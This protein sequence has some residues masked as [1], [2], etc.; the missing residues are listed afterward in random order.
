MASNAECVQSTSEL[1]RQAVRRAILS[2]RS[3]LDESFSLTAMAALAFASRFHFN[4]FFHEVTGI[5]PCQFLYAL[6]LD[7]AKRLLL[8][9]RLKV[10]DICYEVGYNSLGTFT[11]RFRDLVG[12]SPTRFRSQARLWSQGRERSL[13]SA[14]VLDAP[15][16]IGASLFGSIG[17][18]PEFRG[19][20]FIGLFTEPIPQGRPVA[21]TI[22]YGGS[23][24]IAGIRDGKFYLFA[25]A[26]SEQFEP[27]TLFYCPE[28]LRAGGQ[29]ITVVNGAVHG[30]THLS[31]RSPDVADP[32]ILVASSP[33]L[34]GVQRP[35]VAALT[36]RESAHAAHSG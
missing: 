31:L 34:R 24:C 9:T 18:P 4:R 7:E 16:S 14:C 29:P 1:R 13:S 27:S 25:L 17:V 5:P 10:A 33:L 30:I 3:R 8:M 19:L 2:L 11:R 20:I 23:Y 12:V 15:P 26:L 36:Q 22:A 6:R 35:S 21:C 28:V 32:P